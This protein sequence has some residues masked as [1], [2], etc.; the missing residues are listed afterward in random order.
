MRDQRE[1]NP[2]DDGESAYPSFYSG[3][4]MS[5]QGTIQAYSLQKMR[6]MIMA[7][8]QAFSNIRVEKPLYIHGPT[9]AQTVYIDCRKNARLTVQETQND[10]RF[11]RDFLIPL[12]ASNF[13]ILSLERP[14]LGVSGLNAGAAVVMTGETMLE[15][16]QPDPAGLP[17]IYA[18]R[19][20]AGIEVS[21]FAPGTTTLQTIYSARTGGATKA[22]PIITGTDGYAEFWAES[23]GYDIR[24]RDTQGSRI[25]T[26]TIGWNAVNGEAG[27][28][29]PAQLANGILLAQLEAAVAAALWKPG[30]IKAQGGAAVPTGWLACDGSAVNRVTYSA[31]YT[32]LGGA[33]SPWGQ[34]DGSTTF[35]IPDLRGRSMAGVGTAAGDATAGNHVLGSKFGAERH[36]LLKTEGSVPVHG[37]GVTDPTHAHAM[38]S[39]GNYSTKNGP[40]PTAFSGELSPGSGTNLGNSMNAAT[41]VSV[42]NHAGA[43]ASADHNTV[44]PTTAVTMIIKF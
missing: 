10:Y 16:F 29:P 28:I 12:R 6:D 5:L 3:R 36:K 20:M 38:Q 15:R 8:E 33:A 31:L 26:K 35:N 9:L 30:D 2:G 44:P 34:G 40:P 22:N 25:P 32:A 14:S 18:T 39:N 21:V 23:A 43:D 7:L 11:F 24:L 41:G 19:P 42:Q 1:D 13:R 27:G 17:T 37:H 4:P